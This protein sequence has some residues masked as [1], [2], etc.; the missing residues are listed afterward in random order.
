M[1]PAW[2][3]A[4]LITEEKP[5]LEDASEPLTLAQSFQRLLL[6]WANIFPFSA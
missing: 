3:R 5:S 4:G 1:K 6:T 2:S